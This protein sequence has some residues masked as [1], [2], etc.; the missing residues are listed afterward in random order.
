MTGVVLSDASQNGYVN[1]G[2]IAGYGYGI[3]AD[4]IGGVT[5][6]VTNAAVGRIDATGAHGLGVSLPIGTFHNAG[7][8]VASGAYGIGA[9][10]VSGDVDNAA[11]GVILGG[12]SGD[13]V[14]LGGGTLDNAGYIHA[15]GFGVTA[16][17]EGQ[18]TNTGEIRA[19]D[20]GVKL[21][22][23]GTLMN[24]TAGGTNNRAAVIRSAYIGVWTYHSR[25]T[26]TPTVI[27]YVACPRGV[28]QFRC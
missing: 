7:Y 26:S 2:T 1:S 5:W 15:G 17:R 9:F 18:I 22:N 24:G 21:Q 20:V 28:I 4:Y 23:G 14:Y 8:V 27:N 13:G 25:Y 16:A 19:G 10:V 3:L 6:Q 12:A 11:G